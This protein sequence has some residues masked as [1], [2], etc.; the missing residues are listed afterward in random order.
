MHSP[1][2]ASLIAQLATG[3]QRGRNTVRKAKQHHRRTHG[4][5]QP[6]TV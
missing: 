4:S 6:D 3:D 5:R 2:T 1:I